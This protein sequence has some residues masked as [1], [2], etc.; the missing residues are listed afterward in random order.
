[1]H[2]ITEKQYNDKGKDCKGIWTSDEIHGTNCNGKRTL[3]TWLN[4]TCLLIEGKSLKIVATDEENINP[5][6]K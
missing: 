1:M 6:V 5:I 3:M 2:T 4:G